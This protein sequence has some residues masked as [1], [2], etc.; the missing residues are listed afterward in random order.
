[1]EL[2]R[3]ELTT[4]LLDLPQHSRNAGNSPLC[5]RPIEPDRFTLLWTAK[6]AYLKARGLG[7]IESLDQVEI[8]LDAKDGPVIQ[9]GAGAQ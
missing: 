1:M 5:P 7:I 6:E 8:D 2:R 4:D 9:L 3:Q